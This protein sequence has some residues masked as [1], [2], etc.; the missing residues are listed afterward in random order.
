MANEPLFFYHLSSPL[1]GH[2][3][4]YQRPLFIFRYLCLHHRRIRQY[5]RHNWQ[6]GPDRLIGNCYRRFGILDECRRRFGHGQRGV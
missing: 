1:H 5:D 6:L 3:N 4:Y 2:C